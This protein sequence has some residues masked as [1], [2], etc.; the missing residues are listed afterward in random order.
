MRNKEIQAT[1]KRLCVSLMK[2]ERKKTG[3]IFMW[4]ITMRFV[5]EPLVH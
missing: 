4:R 1:K 3:D 2:T 5:C